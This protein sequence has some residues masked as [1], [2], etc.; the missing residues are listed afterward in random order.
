MERIR[1]DLTHE[2]PNDFTHEVL[3]SLGMLQD[4]LHLIEEGNA[5]FAKSIYDSITKIYS[6]VGIELSEDSDISDEEGNPAP[7]YV[8]EKIKG[9]ENVLKCPSHCFSSLRMKSL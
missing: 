6:G 4:Y 8:F 1:N 3:N 9:G 2:V 5:K 7:E